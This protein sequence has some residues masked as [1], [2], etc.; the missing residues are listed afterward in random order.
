MHIRTITFT[1]GATLDIH[2]DDDPCNPRREFDQQ[3]TMIC[4]H[5]K[6]EL[7]D[8]DYEY[9]REDFD[10]WEDLADR[11]REDYEVVA[12]LPLYL[13]NHSGITINTTGFDCRWDSG[14]VGWIFTTAKLLDAM[15]HDAETIAD[16]EKVKRIL[17]AEVAGYDPYLTGDIWGY[18]FKNPPVTCEAC[19]HTEVEEEDSCWGFYG[20]DVVKNGIACNLPSEYRTALENGNYTEQNVV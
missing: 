3:T 6:Y 1:D 7:G 11:I 8:T 15:G 5:P 12:M 4:F 10:N 9:T 20:S 19:G 14:Q 2:T 16:T 18:V 13:Y 17:V